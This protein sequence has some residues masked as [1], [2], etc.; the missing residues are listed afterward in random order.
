[1]SNNHLPGSF[2][3]TPAKCVDPRPVG[4]RWMKRSSDPAVAPVLQVAH[5]WTLGATYGIE[6]TDV[7]TV[8]ESGNLLP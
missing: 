7:P 8:D 1:M 3:L 5:A 6:W 2:S 4:F